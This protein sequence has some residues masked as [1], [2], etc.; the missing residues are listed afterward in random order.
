MI[1]SGAP[2]RI[3]NHACEILAMAVDMLALINTMRDPTNGNPMKIRLGNKLIRNFK[4]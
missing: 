4:V 1:V 2:E 3:P